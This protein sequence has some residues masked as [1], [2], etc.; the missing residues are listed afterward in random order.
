MF[1]DPI[2]RF[3]WIF[4]IIYRN[5]L[6]HSSLVSFLISF[7]EALRRGVWVVFRVENEH[8]TNVGRFRAQRDP[9]LPYEIRREEE[10]E[11]V[12]QAPIEDL[13]APP[14]DEAEES[15]KSAAH[16]TAVMSASSTSGRD[17]ESGRLPIPPAAP[18]SGGLGSSLRR[19]RTSQAA[20]GGGVAAGEG[21]SPVY[22]ALRRATSTFMSAHTQD[23]ERKRLP[24]G[25]D[26]SEQAIKEDGGEDSDD[27]D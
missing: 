10:Q 13:F 22:A 24:A 3:N 7:S 27:S 9:D 21:E 25:D 18:P 5:D 8:C 6:Q 16:P 23:Y 14:L 20:L 19:R 12:D 1:L 15:T 2:L 4:Y 11:A 17:V 26:G